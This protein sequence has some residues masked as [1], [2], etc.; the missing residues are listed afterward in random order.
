[1]RVGAYTYILSV[2]VQQNL[3]VEAKVGCEVRVGHTLISY[4]LPSRNLEVEAKVGCG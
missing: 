3:E 2:T 4:Q 1:M